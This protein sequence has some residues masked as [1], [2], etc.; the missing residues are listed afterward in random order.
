MKVNLK[1]SG[2]ARATRMGWEH[3][4]LD[5]EVHLTI[6]DAKRGDAVTGSIDKALTEANKLA[7][8]ILETRRY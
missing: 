4:P 7:A 3:P 8:K 5:I 6:T 2:V 1:V